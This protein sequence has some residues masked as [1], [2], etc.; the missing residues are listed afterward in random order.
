MVT[1]VCSAAVYA[2]HSAVD[3]SAFVYRVALVPFGRGVGSAAASVWAFLARCVSRGS[4]VTYVY[5]LCPALSVAITA[6][7][8][9]LPVSS[10]IF[11]KGTRDFTCTRIIS[12]T[13][14]GRFVIGSIE[15][16]FYN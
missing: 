11:L 10:A 4:E 5:V 1:P 9:G 7:H 15:A 8:F 2:W 16:D 3:G 12:V 13:N 14:Y 6:N